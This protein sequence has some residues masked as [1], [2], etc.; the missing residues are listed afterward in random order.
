M[1]HSLNL[2]GFLFFLFFWSQVY[3]GVIYIKPTLLEYSST[4]SDQH[5]LSCDGA[6]IKIQNR[7]VT[8]RKASPWASVVHLL[9]VPNAGDQWSVFGPG[10]FALSRTPDKWNH[11]ECRPLSV[12]SLTSQFTAEI[13]PCCGTGQSCS[14]LGFI[15][16]PTQAYT[17]VSLSLPLPK[18]IWVVS[19]FGNYKP[20]HACRGFCV[21]LHFHFS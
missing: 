4:S 10:G 1:V 11:R 20:T 3:W 5:F 18:D 13:H 14:C 8:P 17:A 15:S 6:Q 16:A 2:L 9:H 7:W 21:N 12:A 19:R